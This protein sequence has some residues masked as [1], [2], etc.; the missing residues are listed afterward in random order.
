MA[1][2]QTTLG[3][4]AN[5]V[6]GSATKYTYKVVNSGTKTMRIRVVREVRNAAGKVIKSS[7]VTKNQGPKVTSSFSVNEKAD[8]PAGTYSVRIQIKDAKTGKLLQSTESSLK[9]T[10]KPAPKPKAKA[11]K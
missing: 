2:V 4:I 6:T 7:S 9:V 3:A 8:Y 1:G 11:K 10:A 5:V